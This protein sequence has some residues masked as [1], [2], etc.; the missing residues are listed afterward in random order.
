MGYEYSVD[1]V[2]AI[3]SYLPK[4]IKLMGI[5]FVDRVGDVPK[6]RNKVI[7]V[8]GVDVSRENKNSSKVKM[9][10]HA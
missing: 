7:C 5:D 10:T 2:N 6:M 9:S 4:G 8:N 3:K 1:D